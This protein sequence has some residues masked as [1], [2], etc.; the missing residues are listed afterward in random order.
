MLLRALWLSTVAAFQSPAVLFLLNC[1]AAAAE[2][3]QSALASRLGKPLR[4]EWHGMV[5]QP[6]TGRPGT[7]GRT[8]DAH[9]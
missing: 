1:I 9:R 5:A 7:V 2:E 6:P 3:Y 4:R 8:L